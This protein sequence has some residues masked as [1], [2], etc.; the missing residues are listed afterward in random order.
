MVGRADGSQLARCS[1]AFEKL[2]FGTDEVPE[3]L[4][5][6]LG[7]YRAML[8]ACRCPSRAVRRF[9][10][11]LAGILGVK[12]GREMAIHCRVMT[13][14]MTSPALE[15]CRAGWN[16]TE[17]DCGCLSGSAPTGAEPRQLMSAS[18]VQ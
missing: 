7:R 5:G 17:R 1:H 13:I 11:T 12:V 18:L 8:H 16:Q 2:V 10:E 4:E 6:C 3:N 9:L 15:L 14:T